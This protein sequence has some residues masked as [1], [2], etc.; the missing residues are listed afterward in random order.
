MVQAN[1]ITPA[2]SH[3][4]LVCMPVHLLFALESQ[5]GVQ[6]ISKTLPTFQESLQSTKVFYVFILCTQTTYFSQHCAQMY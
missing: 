5:D 3:S 1:L 6:K 4:G 2:S